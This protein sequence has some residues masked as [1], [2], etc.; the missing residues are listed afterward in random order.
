MQFSY[1]SDFYILGC[2]YE[3]EEIQRAAIYALISMLLEMIELFLLCSTCTFSSLIS[4]THPTVIFRWRYRTDE[5]YAACLDFVAN[6][7]TLLV[8][9]PSLVVAMPLLNNLNQNTF[10]NTDPNNP[11]RG[12]DVL[13]SN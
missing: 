7:K 12:Y 2:K 13:R 5:H 10:F 9:V 11:C 6:Y 4:L 1:N 8:V 3:D